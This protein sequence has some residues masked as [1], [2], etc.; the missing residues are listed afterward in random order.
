[1][2]VIPASEHQLAMQVE[3][4]DFVAA[5]KELSKQLKDQGADLIVA[6]THM[7]E[8]NDYRL[9][10]EAYGYVDII[11]GGHDHHYVVS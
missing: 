3:Y 7:R 11:L 2:V 10:R 5:G 6:M 4:T 1:M 9:A 8:K